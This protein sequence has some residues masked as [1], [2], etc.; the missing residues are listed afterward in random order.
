MSAPWKIWADKES[1]GWVEAYPG[2]QMNPCEDVCHHDDVVRELVEANK[3]LGFWMSGALEDPNVSDA[4]KADIIAWFA[5][6]EHNADKSPNAQDEV[7]ALLKDCEMDAL[8]WASHAPEL[9]EQGYDA[10]YSAALA[11]RIRAAL[12]KIAQHDS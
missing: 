12:A 5:S 10:D 2:Q 9:R 11:V 6:F 4:M 3:R 1:M 7:V 8:G